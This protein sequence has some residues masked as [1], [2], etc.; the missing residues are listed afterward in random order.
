MTPYNRRSQIIL[1]VGALAG[2]P[3]PCLAQ[4]PERLSNNEVKALIDQV[5]EGRDKF[6]GNLDGTFK[7]ST[8]RGPTGETKVAGALQDYQDSTKK[9]Q[10]RFNA[11]YAASAEVATVLK[12]STMIDTFMQTSSSA[13]KGRSEWDRQAANLKR[14]A[15]A[16]GTTF[17]LPDGATVR[18]M[19][20]KETAAAAEAIATA[21]GRFKS[22]LGKEKTLP[23]PD[24]EA[25][26][27]DIDVLIKQANAVKSRTSDGKP[28]TGEV[29]QLVEQV[30]KVQAFVDAH[31][32]P[33]ALANWQA[34]RPS[35]VNLQQAFGLTK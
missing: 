7:G 12:Q 3:V 25:A 34:V 20:D 18:R 14:L 10:E 33:G 16:Y 11:D 21:A 32:I 28:A 24:L 15:A 17:P 31:Q 29:R 26:K 23:K 27:K 19:N 2:W 5:D 13:M 8:L 4:A 22:D 6:E 9:L 1:L 35:L 30:T